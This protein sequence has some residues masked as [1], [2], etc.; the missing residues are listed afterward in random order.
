MFTSRGEIIKE[1]L[2]SFWCFSPRCTKKKK[3]V[4]T[5]I[6]YHISVMNNNRNNILT[7]I[8]CWESKVTLNWVMP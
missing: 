3:I 5:Q 8:A 2:Q 4:C 7:A 6:R 1:C